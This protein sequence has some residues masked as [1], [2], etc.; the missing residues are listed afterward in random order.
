MRCEEVKFLHGV[1]A[2]AEVL[3]LLAGALRDEP[4]SGGMVDVRNAGRHEKAAPIHDR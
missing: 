2:A 3:R 4:P 1:G